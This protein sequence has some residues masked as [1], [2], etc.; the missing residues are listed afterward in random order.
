MTPELL[1]PSRY[2]SRRGALKQQIVKSCCGPTRLAPGDL[3]EVP[4]TASRPDPGNGTLPPGPG[5][6][7]DALGLDSLMAMEVKNTL[8]S[9]LEPRRFDC[10][11]AAGTN[12]ARSCRG[13]ACL[14]GN[15]PIRNT[16]TTDHFASTTA[17]A[18]SLTANRRCGSSTNFCLRKSRSTWRG[19]SASA[20]RWISLPSSLLFGSLLERHKSLRSTFHAAN[21]EPLQRVH[22]TMEWNF[23]R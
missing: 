17:K 15:T 16:I 5:P 23:Q 9:K 19:Q 18:R 4:P 8:A 6:P 3:G 1:A 22:E 2:P 11:P 7:L 14:S 10:Q 20:A 21:G 13:S 12:D